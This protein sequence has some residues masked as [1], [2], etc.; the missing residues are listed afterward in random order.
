MF[1]YRNFV[2][3]QPHAHTHTNIHKSFIIYK[4]MPKPNSKLQ[5]LKKGFGSMEDSFK[6]DNNSHSSWNL[7]AK[8]F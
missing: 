8:K 3:P 1:G 6:L 7:N 5:L 4:G 2:P